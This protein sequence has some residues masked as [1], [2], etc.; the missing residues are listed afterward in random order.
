M[1]RLVSLIYFISGPFALGCARSVAV[2]NESRPRALN[3]TVALG[4]ML[5]IRI[6]SGGLFPFCCSRIVGN[7][8]WRFV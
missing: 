8:A 1:R 7:W 2:A 6:G 5:D 4:R 3:S